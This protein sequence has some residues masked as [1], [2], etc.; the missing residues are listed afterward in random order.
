MTA[1]AFATINGLPVAGWDLHVPYRG[2]W[3]L[4]IAQEDDSGPINPGDVCTFACAGSTL[5]GRAKV[6]STGTRA[7]QRRLRL[8]AGSGAWG[9]RI[10]RKDYP[11]D[12][13]VKA[14]RVAQDAAAAVG[15][16]LGTFSPERAQL[17]VHY[18]R[19][20]GPASVAL[21]QAA[22][23]VPWYVDYAG[24]TQV[25]FRSAVQAVPGSY[26]VEEYNPRTHVCQLYVDDLSIGVGTIISD[27]LDAPI[28]IQSFDLVQDGE[29]LRMRAFCGNAP[30]SI[31]QLE[32]AFRKAVERI[33]SKKLLGPYRYRV[34]GMAVDGR[35]NVQ[36]VNSKI[37]VPDMLLIE[38]WPG[39]AGAHAE[40]TPGALCIVEFAD[41]GDPSLP[42]IT[43]YRGRQDDAYIPQKLSIGSKDP[44]AAIPIAYQ[45]GTVNVLLPPL[46]LRGTVTIGGTPSPFTAVATAASSS[47]LGSIENGSSKVGVGT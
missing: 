47:T 30:E 43:Q 15:E 16:T 21:E 31:T 23:A 39:L 46:F 19:Q 10:P 34:V 4:N 12:A 7:L 37:G 8:I 25:M 38:Q 40:L 45:G 42:I 35:V 33:G 13:G 2:A 20:E 28:T 32:S 24:V 22:G 26:E 11:N 9:T 41:G 29:K 36:A 5:I 1:E 3:V 14:L 6:D 18:A 44:D 27:R 17:G